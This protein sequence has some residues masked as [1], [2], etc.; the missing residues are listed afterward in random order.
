LVLTRGA[1]PTLDR[2]RYASAEGVARGGYVLADSKDG[3]PDVLLLGTGSEVALCIEAHEMLAQEGVASRVV[4]MPSWELFE[5]QSAEYRDSVLPPSIS[6]RVVV[7]EASGFGWTQYAGARGTILAMRSFGA[8]APL[9]QLLQKFGFT[10]EQVVSAAKE[11]IAS[12]RSF[13]EPV[14]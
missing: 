2:A 14:R 1:V 10:A 5:K 12:V 7:E 8:S 4:S 3:T 6:A 13:A 11:Q 9:Q